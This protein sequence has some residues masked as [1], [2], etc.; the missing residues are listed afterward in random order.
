[1]GVNRAEQS[2]EIGA[3]PAACFD[4]IVDFETY[5]EWQE[6]VIATEVLDRHPDGLGRRVRLRVDAKFREVEY[7]LHYHFEHPHRLWW[8]FVEGEGVAYI[9]GEY[10]FEPLDDGTRTRATY[11]LGIDAGVPIPGFVARK[12]N[13]TVMRRSIEETK[14]ESE[15]RHEG[16]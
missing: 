9:D 1:L 5:P 2:L 8:D 12:L 10:V 11:R 15:R 7:V 3:S 4:A 16:A 13:E 6:A 14:A